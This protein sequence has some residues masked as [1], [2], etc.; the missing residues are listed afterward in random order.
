VGIYPLSHEDNE[1]IRRAQKATEID[2]MADW[3]G[4]VLIFLGT[5]ISGYSGALAHLLLMLCR[6]N[7]FCSL[8]S[9][10]RAGLQLKAARVLKRDL[11]L[12]VSR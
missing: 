2:V 10:T 4:L 6:S 11:V 7:I 1:A 3:L 12:F 5:L 8:E 9:V